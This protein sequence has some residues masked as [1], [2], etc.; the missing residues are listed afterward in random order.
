MR[1][2]VCVCARTLHI[3]YTAL[4]GGC[5]RELETFA[6][7]SQPFCWLFLLEEFSLEKMFTYEYLFKEGR[8][9][10]AGF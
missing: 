1:L 3:M 7:L 5:V 2:C 4:D 9:R 10:K 6:G 8:R